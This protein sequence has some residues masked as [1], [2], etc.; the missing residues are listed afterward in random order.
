M[1]AP[2]NPQQPGV[3]RRERVGVLLA[4]AGVMLLTCV[5]YLV[6]ARPG[7]AG[8]DLHFA[9]FLWGVDDGNV[10]RMYLRQHAEGRLFTRDQYTTEPQNPRFVNLLFLA[11]GL[12]SRA[13][14]LSA[15][16]VYHLARVLGGIALLYLIYLLAAEVGLKRRARV[17]AWLLAVFSSGLGWIV[18]GAVTSGA[19][20]AAAGARLAPIDVATGWQA[21]PEAVTFLT[22][23]LNPLFITGVALMCGAFLWGLRAARERGWGATVVCG[24]L[25]LLLGNVHTYDVLVV[26]AVLLL[27]MAGQALRRTLSWPQAGGRYALLA[28]L[29]APG[30]LWQEYVQRVDP[31]W[32]AKL[33]VPKASPPLSGYLLGWGLPLLLALIALG[34]LVVHARRRPGAAPSAEPWPAPAWL[35]AAWLV[36]GFALLYAPVGFQRKLAEGL[37]VPMCLLAGL[38]V[39]QVWGARAPASSFRVA[40]LALLALTVPSNLYFVTD[41]LGHLRVNNRD[42]AGYLLPPAYLTTGELETLRRLGEHARPDQVVLCSSLLG[43]HLPAYASCLVVAGHW[44]ET[45]GFRRYLGLVTAFYRPGAPA[46]VRR[47]VLAQTRADYVVW[48]P[49]ERLLQAMLTGDPQAAEDPATGLPELA[50]VLTAGDTRLYAV[51]RGGG[52][53]LPGE[54]PPPASVQAD[55]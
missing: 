39:G 35:P 20:S 46:E 29:G 9:G 8:P 47:Q 14:G 19:L 49:S 4:A 18:Y 31:I 11:L 54:P 44:D 38:L 40:A 53:S 55:R 7:F 22:L 16:A 51:P 25:L 6:A 21:V 3:S 45:V 15:V 36:V 52:P 33:V 37:H 34:Y 1:I 12:L 17:I 13:T 23:L 43:N 50:P 27:W 24:L 28:V 41:C 48:G 5:P 26:Y 10:Y 2:G 30:V 32:A 42:L